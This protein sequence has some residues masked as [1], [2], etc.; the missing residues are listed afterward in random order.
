M[1][2]IDIL[3]KLVELSYEHLRLI[4]DEKWDEWKKIAEI[5]IGLYNILRKEWGS[6]LNLKE[7]ALLS[8]IKR[9]E[10]KTSDLIRT[11]RNDT[12]EEL[13]NVASIKNAIKGYK[14]TNSQ[15][16]TRSHISFQI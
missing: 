3:D 5:K 8:N 4:N 10:K 14:I 16:N 11:K 15:R 13:K 9:L 12:K 1:E 6:P 2:R 7:V